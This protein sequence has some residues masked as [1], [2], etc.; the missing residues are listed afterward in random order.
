MAYKTEEQ[1]VTLP[2]ATISSDL[3]NCNLNNGWCT[4]SPTLHL[5]S[6]EPL[7]GE[8]ITLIEGTRNG[9]AFACASDTCD[10]PLLE[11]NNSFDFWALSSYG[12]GSEMGNLSAQVDTV[13]PDSAFGS[14]P[15]G[16]SVWVSGVLDMTGSSSD[17]SSG[18]A[19]AEISLD[20]GG[21]WQGLSL[22]AGGWG[23]S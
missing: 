23:Y 15:E 11:G 19:S 6:N 1:T 17:A 18:V 5:T 4:S 14:P 2:E 9:E 20:G 7:P 12:D 13:P 10:V 22:S 3:Q 16:S 21:S 8:V